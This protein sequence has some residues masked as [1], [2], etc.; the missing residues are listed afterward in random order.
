MKRYLSL[1]KKFL[2]KAKKGFTLVELMVVIAIIGLLS[3][4]FWGY[5]AYASR[6]RDTARKTDL[7]HIEQSLAIAHME[8]NAYPKPH[9]PNIEYI[10][11][12]EY[13]S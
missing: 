8:K 2:K 5:E 11:G 6:A 3:S 4:L 12:I 9:N 13:E 1:W 10:D 7:H